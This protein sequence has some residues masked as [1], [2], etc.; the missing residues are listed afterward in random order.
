MNTIATAAR[1]YASRPA[2]ER[3]PSVQAMIDNAANQKAHSRPTIYNAKDL[4]I[5]AHPNPTE[6][7]PAAGRLTL[8][9]PRGTQ[10]GFTHWSFGQLC[11]SVGAPANYLRDLRPAIAADALNYGLKNTPPASDFNLLMQAPNGRPEPTVRACTTDKYGRVWDADLY[12]AIH[13]NIMRHDDRWTTPPTWSGE[14]AGAYRG[15]RDSFLIIVN[16][17]SIVNDPSLRGSIGSSGSGTQQGNTP[18]DGMFRGLLV[19]NSEVGASS[20]TIDQI[21]FR[22]ICGNHMLWGAVIDR[23]FKRKHIGDNVQRDTI[24]EII[25]IAHQWTNR[26]ASQD[27]QIIRTLIDREIAHTRDAVIDELRKIGYS[28][29]DAETAYATA[30]RTEQASPRSYWG[31]A[32]GTTRAS[33]ESG[34]Q[35]GRYILDQLAAKVLA[36]GAALVRA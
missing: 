20:I 25:S 35:D 21:L 27:E 12:T 13:Q 33:Q 19:R 5:V 14:P 10:A 28:K 23:R 26:S 16:G 36:R 2:D 29:D 4:R 32:Q 31:I 15:D 24:R 3:F 7:D 34:Y 1:E 6:Q 8:Q 9:S 30:E 11:R 22:F 17:G 18:T